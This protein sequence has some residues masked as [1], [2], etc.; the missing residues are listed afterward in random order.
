MQSGVWK[1]MTQVLTRKHG[2][3]GKKKYSID[4]VGIDTG[5][6]SDRV[7]GFVK[8]LK[9]RRVNTGD[10]PVAVGLRG[11]ATGETIIKF[12]PESNYIDKFTGKKKRRKA[13]Y[14]INVNLA[15]DIMFKAIKL[16]YRYK[17]GAEKE[18]PKNYFYDWSNKTAD[19]YKQLASEE[20]KIVV[21]QGQPKTR[22]EKRPGFPRNE[23]LDL[24]VY[25]FALA[26]H[27][28]KG[29][30]IDDEYWQLYEKKVAKS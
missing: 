18:K 3:H 13:R 19:Y 23:I 11:T 17:I 1:K 5:Y 27:S 8:A 21:F 24:W 10:V 2:L 4:I 26:C 30:V 7:F 14:L 12:A 9:I 29:D 15:K 6:L 28:F 25:N 22:Y 20:P 16:S